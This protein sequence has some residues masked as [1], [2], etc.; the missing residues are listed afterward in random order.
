M[1]RTARKI[2]RTGLYHIVARGVGKQIIFEEDND[3]LYFLG[4]LKKYLKEEGA[5]LYAYCLMDNHFH[6]LV[7]IESVMDRLMKKIATAYAFYFNTKYERT[8]HLFQDRYKSM[9]VDDNRYLLSVVRYIHNNPA[10]A[11]ICSADSYRWSSWRAYTGSSSLVSTDLVLSLTCGLEGF[12]IFSGQDDEEGVTHLE[13]MERKQ[14]SDRMAQAI[15]NEKLHMTSGTQI[16]GL[17]R[18]ERDSA[19]RKLKEAGLSIRQI[20][21]LTGINRGVVLKS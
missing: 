9:P 10:N 16:Q 15:I 19:L 6:L 14:I 4:L 12:L 5:V 1:P 17:G 20:E 3:F 18:A 21:R 7:K 2:G 8:G 11:G 13:V